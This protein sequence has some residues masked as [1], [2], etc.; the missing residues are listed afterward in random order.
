MARPDKVAAVAEIATSFR[1]SSAAVLTE[2][3]GL[4]TSQLKQLRAGLGEGASYVVV[5]NTLTKLAAA[6]AGVV[7]LDDLLRG[8]TAIAFVSGDPVAAARGLRD[9]ARANS[10]LVI[11]G[12]VLDGRP[13]SVDE[14]RRLADLESREVLLGRLAGSLKG[15][16]QQAVGL[17]AAPLSQLARLAVALRDKVQ[18]DSNLL[19]GGAELP[20]AE[21]PAADATGELPAG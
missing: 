18:G 4:T 19:A 2:Y 16:L 10:L 12:G 6:D 21:P 8:P 11:K 5:K 17:L 15:S 20:G 9:F 14:L 1:R 13:L 3:R 7:G